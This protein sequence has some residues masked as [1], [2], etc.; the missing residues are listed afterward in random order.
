MK[1]ANKLQTIL[2]NVGFQELKHE[3]DMDEPLLLTSGNECELLL[4]F[5]EGNQQI[6]LQFL[7]WKLKALVEDQIMIVWIIIHSL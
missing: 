6:K 2:Q 7:S 1:E 4:R 3:T 5:Y